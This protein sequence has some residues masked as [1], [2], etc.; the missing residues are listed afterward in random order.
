MPFMLSL[1]KDDRVETHTSGE[2]SEDEGHTCRSST[3]NEDKDPFH[4]NAVDTDY[5]SPR[6]TSAEYVTL[7]LFSMH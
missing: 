1:D 7:T 2:D 4:E 3:T 5:F 6:L